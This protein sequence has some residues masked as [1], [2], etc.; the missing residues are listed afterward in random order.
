MARSTYGTPRWG[1][2]VGIGAVIATLATGLPLRAADSWH[3]HTSS[4]GS[5]S[6]RPFPTTPQPVTS[7]SDTHSDSQPEDRETRKPSLAFPP[8]VD[9]DSGSAKPELAKPMPLAPI[10][11]PLA[12]TAES[13]SEETPLAPATN[14]N[15]DPAFATVSANSGPESVGVVTLGA[16]QP[17][18]AETDGVV[19]LQPDRKLRRPPPL[20]VESTTLPELPASDSSLPAIIMLDGYE[21][22][23]IDS[24]VQ[25]QQQYNSWTSPRGLGPIVPPSNR[26]R[27]VQGRAGY[28]G[29]D[30]FGRDSSLSDLEIMPYVVDGENVYYGDMRFF[31][32]EGDRMGTNVGLGLRHINDSQTGWMGGSVWFDYDRFYEQSFYQLGLGL[33]ATLDQF[34][35]RGNGYLPLNQGD[36]ELGTQL[37][38]SR[39]DGDNLVIYSST[40]LMRPM[41][42]FD[43][44]V[45]LSIPFEEWILRGYAGSYHFF[46]DDSESINGLKARAEVDWGHLNLSTTVT[47]DDTYGTDVMVGVGVEWPQL[48]DRPE[49]LNSA[50]SPL[51]FARRNHNI[52]V[53]RDYRIN[54]TV[55]PLNQPGQT[56]EPSVPA[57]GGSGDLI[58][59][60][61]IAPSDMWDGTLEW[62][63][64]DVP[65]DPERVNYKPIAHYAIVPFQDVTGDFIVP[66]V[67]FS[68]GGIASVTFHVEGSEAVVNAPQIVDAY[69]G[70][71]FEAYVVKLDASEFPEHDGAFEVF[72]TVQPNDP[73]AQARVISLQLFSNINGTLPTAESYVDANN[74]SDTTGDGSAANPFAT[75]T[76]ARES[77]GA[78][79]EVE[80]GTIILRNGE[81]DYA[82]GITSDV[83]NERWLTI[84]AEDGH[85]PVINARGETG[86]RGLRALR[87]KIDG[88]DLDAS[89]T[90]EDFLIRSNLGQMPDSSLWL[91]N[92]AYT[93][94]GAGVSGR[95]SSGFENIYY[96]DFSATEAKDGA[97]L[98]RLARNVTIGVIGSD[99]F[100]A[101]DAVIGGH[102]ADT[103]NANIEYHPDI[104]QWWFPDIEN[105]LLYGVTTGDQVSA[106]G[107]FLRGIDEA[108]DIAVV[109]SVFKTQSPALSSQIMVKELSHLLMYGNTFDQSLHLR[110]DG[111]SQVLHEHFDIVGNVFLRTSSEITGQGDGVNG[112]RWVDNYTIETDFLSETGIQ[113]GTP[114]WDPGTLIPTSGGNLTSELES[115]L[116]LDTSGN[117]RPSTGSVLGAFQP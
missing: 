13:D 19:T 11:R 110:D 92:L 102:V 109:N 115:L 83:L 36:Q 100:T 32:A 4:S 42:G 84:K 45:G 74:G 103:G 117:L 25:Q 48:A 38:T 86:S 63:G 49:G 15:P 14:S 17:S 18:D 66:V 56:P 29:F 51:R 97:V 33:E 64:R 16:S 57:P 7:D 23:D 31:V 50:M 59:D 111:H 26:I 80:G 78:S 107:V 6:V 35:I 91:H 21:E 43:W 94:R 87:V 8:K 77:L 3:A 47:H 99:A 101:T 9:V 34:E 106:Q 53:D 88:V 67:A 2:I 93:G 89:V 70:N 28:F 62:D 58:T 27:G 82:T 96:T 54:E 46:A 73:S 5:E 105:K 30:T 108:R 60:A 37:L 112:N 81:Y 39:V 113:S 68:K 85:D 98:G 10:R 24:A 69:A 76:Q 116:L 41:S 55:V 104:W 95:V 75:I 72:A 1:R 71:P 22:M 52:I 61:L 12:G 20:A 65:E 44:E 40:S 90:D 79:G 114:D